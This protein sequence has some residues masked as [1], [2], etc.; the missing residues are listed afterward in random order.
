M[1]HITN[2]SL[3][4]ALYFTGSSNVLADK[5]KKHR[6]QLRSGY[7]KVES[8]EIYMVGA[9]GAMEHVRTDVWCTGGG[10]QKFRASS[11]AHPYPLN[12]LD[13]FGNE[14]TVA[15]KAIAESVL[16]DGDTQIEGGSTSGTTTQ[17]VQ[18]VNTSTGLSYYRTFS[19]VWITNSNGAVNSSLVISERF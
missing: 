9:N 19:Y 1:K 7:D 10:S 13:I 5:I 14:Y 16:I 6:D 3:L 8:K 17:T 2:I 4:V 18:F 12:E 11:I 15:E